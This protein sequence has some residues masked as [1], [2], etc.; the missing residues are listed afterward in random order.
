MIL[1]REEGG[2]GGRERDRERHRDIDVRETSIGYL[3]YVP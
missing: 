2:V 1:E 3:E